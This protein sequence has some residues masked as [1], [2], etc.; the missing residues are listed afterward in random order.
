MRT[1]TIQTPYVIPAGQFYQDQYNSV[2]GAFIRTTGPTNS[3]ATA[4]GFQ[5][6]ETI[7]DEEPRMKHYGN[8]THTV[9]KVRFYENAPSITWIWPPDKFVDRYLGGYWLYSVRASVMSW[10]TASPTVRTVDWSDLSYEALSSM[11]PSFSDA[12]FMNDLIELRQIADLINPLGFRKGW[13]KRYRKGKT[14]VTRFD[15]LKSL[16]NFDLW[17]QFGVKPLIASAQ[18][19]TRLLKEL[20]RAIAKLRA[21]NGKILTRHFSRRMDTITLPTPNA[22]VFTGNGYVVKQSTYWVESPVYHASMR[23]KYD[24]SRF[25]DF[26]LAIQAWAQAHGL[27]KPLRIAWNAIPMSFVVDWFVDIGRW[28]GS[29]TDGSVLP[30]VVEDFCASTKFRYKTQADCTFTVGVVNP[31]TVVALPIGVRE[32]GIYD[33]RRGQPSTTSR[34][35][36]GLPSVAKVFTLGALGV[37]RVEQR[38]PLRQPPRMRWLKFSSRVAVI[39]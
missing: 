25:S 34:L 16:A 4:L 36:F 8:C 39:R 19:V 28:L 9:T 24:L 5:I 21:E 30:I 3:P 18:E 1:R 10:V 2:T 12:S 38:K 6:D 17:Y 37:Q 23:F 35:R 14:P 33:R 13:L 31:K 11:R 32:H 22:T 7:V 29:L 20:P 15:Q 26:E 27:D